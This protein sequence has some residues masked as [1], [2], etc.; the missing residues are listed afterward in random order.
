MPEG[1]LTHWYPSVR[2]YGP[3]P[4]DKSKASVQNSF[5]NWQSV[6]LLPDAKPST[7]ETVTT[8]IVTTRTGAVHTGILKSEDAKR[9][10]I[11]SESGVEVAIAK[12]Q[13]EE[14][15]RRQKTK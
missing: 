14:Q 6:H 3:A 15:V 4:G 11:V 12:D 8:M 1:V 5:L 13:I 2:N 7:T 10:H 9:I